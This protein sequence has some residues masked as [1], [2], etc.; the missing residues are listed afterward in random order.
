MTMRVIQTN[1]T[2]G[3]AD[4]KFIAREDEVYYYNALAE[5]NN[6]LAL[7]QGGITRRPGKQW[8]REL[9]P[10]LTAINLAGA[11]LT[12]PHGG[13]AANLKDG[14]ESTVSVTADNISTTNPFIVAAVDLGAAA[15]VTAF[16]LVNFKVS[17]GSLSAEFFV[18]YSTDNITF[19]NYGSSIDIDTTTRSRRRRNES[20]A[21]TARYWR[22]ARIGATDLAATVTLSEIRMWA[23][24][25]TLSAG[26]LFPFS[27]GPSTFMHAASDRNIDVLTGD[28]YQT[29]CSIPHLSAELS[30]TNF[31]QSIDTM[32]L[33]HTAHAPYRVFH[34]GAD[35]EFDYRAQVF[36][37]IPK[38]DY[39]AGTG[40]VD[41]VQT[42]NVSGTASTDKFTL[43]FE[44][45]ATTTITYGASAAIAAAAME[46]ALRALANVAGDTGL[47][48]AAITDG[49]TV[50]LSGAALGHRPHTAMK[51]F[52]LK[53]NSVWDVARTTRGQYEGEAIF[54]TTRGFP[55]CGTFYQ[56][57]LHLAGML[58]VQD[59]WLASVLNDRYNLDT[60]LDDVTKALQFRAETDQ[61]APIYQVVPGFHLT[62]FTSDSE[63][64]NPVEPISDQSVL[65]RATQYGSK[66][67]VRVYSVDD[68]QVFI[69]GS[70]DDDGNDIGTSVRLFAFDELKQ[71]YAGKLL[72]RFSASL[73]KNPVDAALRKS[74]S[75][76]EADILLMPNEDGTATSL[77]MLLDD[78]VEAFMPLSTRAG[79]KMLAVGADKRRRVYWITERVINGVTRRYV[80]MWNEN[81]LFD[82]G[83]IVTIESESFTASNQQADYTWTFTNPLSADAIGVR[84]N[85]G[86]LAADDFEVDLGSKTVTLNAGI[87]ADVA[88][89]DVVEVMPM[90]NTVTG[91]GHLEGETIQT[92]I[93]GSEGD[94]VTVSGGSFTLP[95]YADREIQYGFDFDVSGKM[96]PLRVP[97]SETL[98]GQKVR[99]VNAYLELFK[100]GCIEV[101][102]ND[103]DWQEV[104]LVEMDDNVLDRSEDELLFTGNK[105]IDGLMGYAVGGVFEF[106]QPG[107][108]PFTLL[109]V[110]R[111]VKV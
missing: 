106:R 110:T 19:H 32:L 90:V 14:D 24:S 27:N 57:R 16:D 98:V 31:T 42:L 10:Q 30:V 40:G 25:V 109:A 85:G 2:A 93:D 11:T 100:T 47:T 96:M 84:L 4:P 17:T 43:E 79:D 97:G 54:S 81:L 50:T 103:G 62:F 41:E 35:D 18:Q 88:A 104:L 51:V 83:S 20:G 66:E 56:S 91:L 101:R 38:Y 48:V 75:A 95:A 28:V 53:G 39:G 12:V 55:R 60:S 59:G 6:L 86:R 71:R 107:P 63:F 111:E 108:A 65:K 92:Y 105:K 33:F 15:A 8:V 67:G 102:A 22:F 3:V 61:P 52:V 69:Q 78:D 13:T 45:Y 9:A 46:T 21:V 58:G 73:I 94:D 64:Y 74:L 99:V 5:G 7:P 76:D 1:F 36:T 89:G 29:S 87:A 44:G 72:S 82:C 77:T 26:K 68:A 23:A 49:F 34:Q 70:K 80:E 37:N